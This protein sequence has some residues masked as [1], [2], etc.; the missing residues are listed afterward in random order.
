MSNRFPCAAGLKS[1][2]DQLDAADDSVMTAL[3]QLSQLATAFQHAE[4]PLQRIDVQFFQTTENI[5]TK[6]FDGKIPLAEGLQ[7]VKDHI[8]GVIDT[9]KI[10]EH[11]KSLALLLFRDIDRARC[12]GDTMEEH[13][14]RLLLWAI[15]GGIQA[16]PP[17]FLCPLSLCIMQDPVILCESEISYEKKEIQGWLA[18]DDEKRCPVSLKKLKNCALA[19]NKAIK[20]LTSDWLRTK[21][22]AEQASSVK[23]L[24]ES[25]HRPLQVFRLILRYRELLV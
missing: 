2:R 16:P 3:D 13:S 24:K 6:I 20:A 15:N 22:A 21:T 18:K 12:R 25:K 14:I 11:L 4:F 19:E 9:D 17:E 8:H 10:K 7:Q 5:S 1:L 23:S